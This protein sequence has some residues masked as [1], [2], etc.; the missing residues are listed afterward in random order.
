MPEN[1]EEIVI[2]QTDDDYKFARPTL[3]E[4]S[5][6]DYYSGYDVFKVIDL[7]AYKEKE[8]TQ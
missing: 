4:L 5:I 8:S 7:Q 6:V 2:Y 3:K 1:L